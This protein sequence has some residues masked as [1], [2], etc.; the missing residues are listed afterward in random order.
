MQQFYTVSS[1][2]TS[3]FSTPN[4]YHVDL[5]LHNSTD[6]RCF[7]IY[8]LI[9]RYRNQFCLYIWNQ[10]CYCVQTNATVQESFSLSVF[11]SSIKPS[12][13][14]DV[15]R[16]PKYIFVSEYF[17]TCGSMFLYPGLLQEMF[18]KRTSEAIFSFS[19]DVFDDRQE[20][21][22]YRKRKHPAY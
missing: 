12:L 3:N 15:F 11:L 10:S 4:S 14:G 2:R 9:N 7:V 13:G 19:F 1:Q 21:K 16:T 18:R 6:C 22:N 17:F 5:L 8:F 20:R